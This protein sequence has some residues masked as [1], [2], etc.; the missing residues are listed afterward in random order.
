M[1]IDF[2]ETTLESISVRQDR[3]HTSSPAAICTTARTESEPPPGAKANAAFGEHE[4]SS[5][6][7]MDSNRFLLFAIA[8]L[9]HYSATIAKMI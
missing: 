8:S 6:A 1:G 2:F 7:M 3:R 9:N 4:W 5:K